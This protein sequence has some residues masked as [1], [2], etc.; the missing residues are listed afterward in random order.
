MAE[1]NALSQIL[2]KITFASSCWISFMSSI[3]TFWK[4]VKFKKKQRSSTVFGEY[5]FFWHFS[6]KLPNK[7]RTIADSEG[8][9]EQ[10]LT[11]KYLQ[12]YQI[13]KTLRKK[14]FEKVHK[15]S[16]KLRHFRSRNHEKP[17]SLINYPKKYLHMSG[18]MNILWEISLRKSLI[19]T[20]E[21]PLIRCFLA[22]F[23]FPS[24]FFKNN[25]YTISLAS[26]STC[27]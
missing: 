21:T 1:K 25:L 27:D 3:V 16:L 5:N 11:Q 18:I 24:R 20:S 19:S 22:L 4:A 10:E 15:F 8:G 12:I 17:I 6:Q 7:N 9:N 13:H 26:D 23:L 2:Q 14:F